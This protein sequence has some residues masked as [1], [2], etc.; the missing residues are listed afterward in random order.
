VVDYIE[1][2]VI[3]FVPTQ[4]CGVVLLS[5]ARASNDMIFCVLFVHVTAQCDCTMLPIL[6]CFVFCSFLGTTTTTIA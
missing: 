3:L 5:F 2:L 4:D 1:L 6:F